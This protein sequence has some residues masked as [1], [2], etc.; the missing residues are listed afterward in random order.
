MPI[1]VLVV[2]MKIWLQAVQRSAKKLT[3]TAR[4]ALPVLFFDYNCA[5]SS[6][7]YYMF[8]YWMCK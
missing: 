6:D 5:I 1:W 7:L 3:T 4:Q 2:Q 8:A